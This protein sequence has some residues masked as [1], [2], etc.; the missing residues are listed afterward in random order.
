MPERLG[1]IVEVPMWP[2]QARE[3]ELPVGVARL[4]LYALGEPQSI[5]ATIA[6][7]MATWVSRW[8]KPEESVYACPLVPYI[9]DKK[10][11]SFLS[12]HSLLDQTVRVK[13]DYLIRCGS[14][15]GIASVLQHC[16]SEVTVFIMSKTEEAV[17]QTLLFVD[18]YPGDFK[19][20]EVPFLDRL[21]V[22]EGFI[23]AADGHASLEVFGTEEFILRRCLPP[24][25]D[26]RV[27]L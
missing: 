16:R 17:R 12:T 24:L 23:F 8:S 20:F 6:N 5:D 21:P 2:A 3:R 19:T 15:A 9:S 13:Q 11:K 10:M 22:H 4:L 27:K 14:A 18:E 1:F 25:L 26:G 7:D